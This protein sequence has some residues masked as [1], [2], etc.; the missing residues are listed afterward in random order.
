MTKTEY[1]GVKLEPEQ[2]EALDDEARAQE[3]APATLA[4]KFIVA[5]LRAKGWLKKVKK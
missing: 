2:R 5:G 1:L 3:I 4:R